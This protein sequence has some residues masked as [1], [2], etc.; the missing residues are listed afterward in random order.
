MHAYLV[1]VLE[2]AQSTST[3]GALQSAAATT[4]VVRRQPE[5]K[6]ATDSSNLASTAKSH[7]VEIAACA[8]S[9]AGLAYLTNHLMHTHGSNISLPGL[10]G[11]STA[12]G[13][14][15][16]GFLTACTAISIAGFASM[17]YFQRASNFGSGFSGYAARIDSATP[18]SAKFRPSGVLSPSE[19]QQLK[20]RTKEEVAKGIYRFIFDLP[21]NYSILG[22]PIGQHV[23]IRG[24]VGDHTVVR[25]YTPGKSVN[26]EGS[27]YSRRALIKAGKYA[28]RCMLRSPQ[29]RI[30]AI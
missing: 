13:N 19:Y 15:T 5:S 4:Q 1:G 11:Q 14:F 18:A 29:F 8:V 27:S 23:A 2:G 7:C 20:L 6:P 28:D 16:R 17:Q 10:Q 12:A 24:Q 30:I 21:S 9:A 3:D 25:S 26:C 22:L